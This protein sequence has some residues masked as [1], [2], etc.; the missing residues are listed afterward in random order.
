MGHSCR[1]VRFLHWFIEVSSFRCNS[2]RLCLTNLIYCCSSFSS[3]GV[4][5]AYGQLGRRTQN[6]LD[7]LTPKAVE[8]PNM[9]PGAVVTSF[10]VGNFHMLVVTSQGQG[11]AFSCGMNTQGQLGKGRR[12]D[13]AK[14]NN[15]AVVEGLYGVIQVAA[16]SETS[17]FLKNDGTVWSCGKATEGTL[18]RPP[19]QIEDATGEVVAVTVEETPAACTIAFKVSEIGA[20]ED[21]SWAYSKSSKGAISCW[22]SG[23]NSEWQA[24][25]STSERIFVPT[26]LKLPK[27]QQ[28]AQFA[29][30]NV[31][32]LILT[33]EE[34]NK[35]MWRCFCGAKQFLAVQNCL[36][37]ETKQPEKPDIV[38]AEF[39]E[40]PFSAW[41]PKTDNNLAPAQNL[42]NTAEVE[43]SPEKKTTETKVY[44]PKAPN[45]STDEEGAN[46][47]S[48]PTEETK[49]G[50]FPTEAGANNK[51]PRLRKK[52]APAPTPTPVRK[53]RRIQQKRDGNDN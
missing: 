4:S 45:L 50:A 32:S 41:K 11:N 17:F 43:S 19:K 27:G 46:E 44:E 48:K 24:G 39:A 2:A 53:S 42:K 37:C 28:I 52:R 5:N 34:I 25:V 22:I 49:E 33:Q 1:S 26:K 14:E 21:L 31:H 15:L 7:N 3:T 16:G 38:S 30:G 47:E 6:F 23:A 40:N 12:D 51:T 36:A 13:Y 10:A 29:G 35:K 8:I 9:K 20:K 18:G